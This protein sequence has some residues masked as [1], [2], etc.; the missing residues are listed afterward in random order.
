MRDRV[1]S[2]P[3]KKKKK[4]SKEAQGWEQKK[5][6]KLN[7]PV[8]R[9]ISKDFAPMKQEQNAIQKGRLTEQERNSVKSK[10]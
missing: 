4:T 2:K 10:M 7:C 3:K 6:P 5:T 9:A 8:F 1:Q